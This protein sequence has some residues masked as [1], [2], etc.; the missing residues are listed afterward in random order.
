M[1]TSGVPWSNTTQKEWCIGPKIIKYFYFKRLERVVTLCSFQLWTIN[2]IMHTFEPKARSNRSYKF[3]GNMPSGDVAMRLFLTI[4]SEDDY[5]QLE[6]GWRHSW[7][8]LL[9]TLNRKKIRCEIIAVCS[10]FHSLNTELI[11]LHKS[12][13]LQMTQNYVVLIL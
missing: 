6:C 9:F 4:I 12:L 1:L 7:P 5:T 2:M 13:I 11:Y 8:A 3:L 10:S